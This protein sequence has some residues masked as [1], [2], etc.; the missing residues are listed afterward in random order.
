M[1]IINLSIEEGI[2][3]CKLKI[4]RVTPIFK[5]GDKDKAE[6]Y[7]PISI[8]PTITKIFE[9]HIA[10]HLNKYL[11]KYNLLHKAQSGFREKHS[12]QTALIHLIDQWIMSIDNENMIGTIFL[13]L[14]KAFDLVDHSVLIYKLKLLNFSQQSLRWFKSYLQNREQIVKV[15]NLQSSSQKVFTGVPQ[16]SILG[17]LLFIIYINDLP[18]YAKNCSIDMYADDATMHTHSKNL[19]EIESNRQGDL[20]GI[21]KWCTHNNMALKAEGP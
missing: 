21:E 15:G 13:D 17:P 14:K 9:R 6:H 19:T 8:L 20:S 18:L 11:S 5:G 4:A 10:N 16:G 2:F 12:C 3:P 7:R 1:H